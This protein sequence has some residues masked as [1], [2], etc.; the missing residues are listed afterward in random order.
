VLISGKPEISG[1]RPGMTAYAIPTMETPYQKRMMGEI[2]RLSGFGSGKLDPKD[3][4]RTAA[5][6]VS[7]GSDPVITG[8]PT[9]A[10]TPAVYDAVR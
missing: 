4:E 3:Y 8:K 2:A 6:L 10:W 9:G 5:T 1:P 7:G